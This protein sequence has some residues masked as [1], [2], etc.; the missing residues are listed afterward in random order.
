MFADRGYRGPKQINDTDIHLP[1][2]EKN[3]TRAKRDKHKRRAAI[4]PIIGHLK[5][6]YRMARNFLKGS[7][8]DAVNL[9]LA[10]SAMNFPIGMAMPQTNDEHVESRSAFFGSIILL[11]LAKPEAAPASHFSAKTEI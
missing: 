9:M 8:G 11:P 10:A 6:D 7:F 5:H 3:I 4:E 2:P 1:K